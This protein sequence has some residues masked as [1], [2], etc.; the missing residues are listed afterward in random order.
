LARSLPRRCYPAND[1]PTRCSASFGS[2][3]LGSSETPLRGSLRC[4]GRR[5][6]EPSG[7][8]DRQ[9]RSRRVPSPVQLEEILSA[10]GMR[11]LEDKGW[12]RGRLNWGNVVGAAWRHSQRSGPGRRSFSCQGKPDSAEDVGSPWPRLA[13]EP[14]RSGQ[15][16]S[17]VGSRRRATQ[18]IPRCEA[19]LPREAPGRARTYRRDCSADLTMNP[20]V[21]WRVSPGQSGYRRQ[22]S[23]QSHYAQEELGGSE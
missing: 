10:L 8:F 6:R 20:G 2:W 21:F 18:P 17:P 4:I 9:N 23:R 15:G 1:L 7:L 16:T 5:S 11:D 14:P 12:W 3:C 13:A 22:S 19:A